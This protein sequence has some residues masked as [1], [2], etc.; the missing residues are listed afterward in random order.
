MNE[1]GLDTVRAPANRG[2]RVTF[3]GLGINLALGILYTWSVISKGVPDDWGWSQADKSWP[4]A[5][6]CLVFCLVMVPA[7]QMQDRL[8]PRL[9]ATI[10]GHHVHPQAAASL[11]RRTGRVNALPRKLDSVSTV[12]VVGGH[13]SPP[14]RAEPTAPGRITP[15]AAC[16]RE[17]Q[18]NTYPIVQ[19]IANNDRFPFSN[20]R[21]IPMKRRSLLAAAASIAV[22]T[23]TVYAAEK[24]DLTD[25]KCVLNGN[26]AAKDVDGS[27]VDYKGGKI[28]FCCTNCPKAFTEKVVSADNPDPVL[29]ARGNAQLVATKQA[30]QAKCPFT[31]GPLKTELTVAGATI[32]FCCDNCKSKAS[33]LEGDEQLIALFGDAAF[34]KAAFTVGG[35]K[36][37]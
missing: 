5:V 32:R 35:E 4:Y 1:S 34:K 14:L 19:C 3:A 25:I 28:Y 18:R 29:A 9:V 16:L 26:A 13:A 24:I 11:G 10:G 37:E 27:S 23:M 21:T 22:L 2:W 31:G 12:S 36:E 33:K 15:P 8:G 20:Q 7:G 30:K 6:A 17:I